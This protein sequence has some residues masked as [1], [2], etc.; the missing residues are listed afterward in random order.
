LDKSYLYTYINNICSNPEYCP[1][2]YEDFQ[3][4]EY[5][6]IHCTAYQYVWDQFSYDLDLA[7]AWVTH[8]TLLIIGKYKYITQTHTSYL[9]ALLFRSALSQI[10]SQSSTPSYS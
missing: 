7:S 8:N 3:S 6:L 2:C 1:R 4:T 5:A 10:R 9:L